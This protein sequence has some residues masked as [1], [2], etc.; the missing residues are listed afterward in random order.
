VSF[1]SFSP[2]QS[3]HTLHDDFVNELQY[4]SQYLWASIAKNGRIAK[5]PVALQAMHSMY[6]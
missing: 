3:H 6:L 2:H 4:I 1:I 5:K